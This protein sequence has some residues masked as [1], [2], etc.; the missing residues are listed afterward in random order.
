ME[1]VLVVVALVVV[2][3]IVLVVNAVRLQPS[4]AWMRIWTWTA[5]SAAWD[6]I[7]SS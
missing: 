2:L 5:T 3:L 7:F 1:I 6:S 4:T